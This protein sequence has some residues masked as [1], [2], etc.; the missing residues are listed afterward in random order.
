[1]QQVNVK[2]IK[3]GM[4]LA[5]EV[6]G[7]NGRM[8]LGKGVTLEDKHLRILNMWGVSEIYI[9][10][11]EAEAALNLDDF[12]PAAEE[13]V[14]ARF[15]VSEPYPPH[16]AE[17]RR[18]CVLHFAQRLADGW[19]PE[20]KPCYAPPE[21]QSPGRIPTLQ[22]LVSDEGGLVSLPDVF[23]RINEALQLPACTA[24]HLADIISKDSGL[25]A[26]L[27][28]LVNSPAL[29]PGRSVDSLT[30]GVVL[31]GIREVSQLALSVTVISTFEG[32]AL[33]G[34]PMVEFWKHSLA[35]AVFARILAARLNL[36]DPERFFVA[37]MLHDIGRLVL[38]KLAPQATGEVFRR[39]Y[40]QRIPTWE[41]EKDLFGY[42]HCDV[43]HDLMDRW[44]LP[45]TL[46]SVIAGHHSPEQSE[47]PLESAIV[48]VADALTIALGYGNNGQ[49]FFTGLD[50]SSWNL[51]Q[52]NPSVLAVV[53]GQAQRQL[54]DIYTAFLG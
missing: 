39:A 17:L 47:T 4:T 37:G 28:R 53:I 51:L 14:T 8:L 11:D 18:Q 10:G 41:A 29:S 46:V 31:L 5:R 1:M 30:R 40:E 45:T 2:E 21:A 42:T 35:C 13:Y 15:A 26:K 16:L 7:S 50:D 36:P 25:S 12:L 49:P 22:E 33:Q 9:E 20:S 44:R 43:A 3:P 48:A 19:I 23:H 34:F 27:L 6:C 24:N 38:L 52:C 32:Q 54:E